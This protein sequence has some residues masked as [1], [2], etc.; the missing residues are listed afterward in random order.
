MKDSEL[1]ER[2]KQTSQNLLWHSESDYPF[3]T[4]YWENVNDIGSKVLQVTNCTPKT[5]IETRELNR[6]C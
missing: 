3:T 4:I 6:V 1:I 5:K 2:L